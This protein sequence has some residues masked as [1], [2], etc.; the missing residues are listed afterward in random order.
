[1]VFIILYFTETSEGGNHPPGYLLYKSETNN[2]DVKFTSDHVL[3][4]RGFSLDVRSISCTES[5]YHIQEVVVAAG[6]TLE[7]AIVSDTGSDGNYRNNA[8]QD[9]NIITDTNQV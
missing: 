8:R 1:M 3:R 9:W 2:V 5:G 6:E 7:G 4:F